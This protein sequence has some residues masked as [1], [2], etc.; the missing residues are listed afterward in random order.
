MIL[1]CR[2]IS[3]VFETRNGH[4]RALEKITFQT[5]EQEF[6]CILGPSGCGKTTLLK[7]IAGLLEP[8]HGEVIYDGSGSEGT[9]LNSLVFQE[10]G[11]FPWMNVIDNVSFGLEMRR[12][13]KKERY[14]V[15][16]E[17]IEKVGLK[18]FLKNYPHELSVGMKQRVGLAR[19]IVNDP[20]ILLMDEPFGSIDAQTKLILQDELLKIW[21]QYRKPIIYVTHDIEEA[22]LLGDRV[23]VLTSSP[24]K[25]KEEIKVELPR[26]RDIEIKGTTAFTQINMKIWHIIEDEVRKTMGR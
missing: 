20:A 25:I 22:V 15:A 16:S 17:V 7:I 18:R 5:E 9:P 21:S 6:L 13:K 1:K 11:L 23:V 24:G 14:S 2:N 3:K 12:I 10:H 8:T 19:A 26:P 4:I